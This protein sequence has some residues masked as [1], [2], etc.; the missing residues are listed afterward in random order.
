[1]GFR[2]VIAGP[3]GEPTLHPFNEEGDVKFLPRAVSV[4]ADHASR[5][6]EFLLFLIMSL[7]I[8]QVFYI[9]PYQLGSMAAAAVRLGFLIVLLPRLG[10]F[11]HI[12]AQVLNRLAL[13][14]PPDVSVSIGGDASNLVVNS[15]SQTS[16]SCQ[17]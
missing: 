9:F 7:L 15:S 8:P 2:F 1:V 6:R 5:N 4:A 3:Y 13:P 12:I 10:S 11:V 17:K 16:A 14:H